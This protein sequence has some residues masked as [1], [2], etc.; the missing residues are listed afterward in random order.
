MCESDIAVAI[1]HLVGAM[2]VT[3]TILP[4]DGGITVS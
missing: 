4:L 3:G 2:S 1:R